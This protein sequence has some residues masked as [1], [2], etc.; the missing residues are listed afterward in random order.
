M[1][2]DRCDRCLQDACFPLCS[3]SLHASLCQLA[4]SRSLSFPL[5]TLLLSSFFFLGISLS[6]SFLLSLTFTLLRSISP[7][8]SLHLHVVPALMQ[9]LITNPLIFEVWLSLIWRT[10]RGWGNKERHEQLGQVVR[11]EEQSLSGLLKSQD[12]CDTRLLAASTATDWNLITP[13][14]TVYTNVPT[15][16]CCHNLSLCYNACARTP[17]RG[18]VNY[19]VRWLIQSVETHRAQ[20][21]ESAKCRKCQVIMVCCTSHAM[22]GFRQQ[23]HHRYWK[24]LPGFMCLKGQEKVIWDFVLSFSL[25]KSSH[26]NA[27][28]N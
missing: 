3:L 6:L 27:F 19:W 24:P 9:L 4:R 8:V 11:G 17:R 5:I 2:C 20:H 13:S 10:A 14:Y 25:L 18:R 7:S 28:F 1:G 26:L 23:K 16:H 12:A 22:F 15:F 21:R